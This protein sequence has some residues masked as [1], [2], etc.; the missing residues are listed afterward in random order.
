MAAWVAAWLGGWLAGSR[1]PL[2]RQS[3]PRPY[4]GTLGPGHD[5]GCPLRAGGGMSAV[6]AVAALDLER[7]LASAKL[8]RWRRQRGTTGTVYGIPSQQQPAPWPTHGV[9]SALGGE[10][11]V[12]DSRAPS[13]RLMPWA[14][15]TAPDHSDFAL[16]QL[17]TKHEAQKRHAATIQLR[18]TQ[19]TG[20]LQAL[21]KGVTEELGKFR[22]QRAMPS[23]TQ[24][25]SQLH[26]ELLECQEARQAITRTK[27][28]LAE[29]LQQAKSKRKAV[30][31]QQDHSAGS[32][33]ESSAGHLDLQTK[34]A[35]LDRHFEDVGAQLSA[36]T[37]A[38]KHAQ[39]EMQSAEQQ[40]QDLSDQLS[41]ANA[42]L[43][44]Q[45]EK[46]QGIRNYI[47]EL[48]DLL[49]KSV[50]AISTSGETNVELYK[51]SKRIDAVQ[52]GPVS[53]QD[54]DGNC[55]ANASSVGPEPTLVD[56]HF[57]TPAGQPLGLQLDEALHTTRTGKTTV[58]TVLG[59]VD[60]NSQAALQEG[61]RPGLFLLGINGESVDNMTYEHVLNQL[62]RVR[63]L[64]LTFGS[65]SLDDMSNELTE[66]EGSTHVDSIVTRADDAPK[67]EQNPPRIQLLPPQ[68]TIQ[69]AVNDQQHTGVVEARIK[70]HPREDDPWHGRTEIL[71]PPLQTL[72]PSTRTDN[73]KTVTFDKQPP[74]PLGILFTEYESRFG[75]HHY[76][77]IA[78]VQPATKSEFRELVEGLI[79]VEVNGISVTNISMPQL[80]TILKARPVALTFTEHLVDREAARAILVA[81]AAIRWKLFARRQRRRRA[82]LE[83]GGIT[84]SQ[85]Y[86]TSAAP[87]NTRRA[88][89]TSSGQLSLQSF[90]YWMRRGGSGR[91]NVVGTT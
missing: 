51:R 87:S 81:S 47:Y 53:G 66:L 73:R 67:L 26:R 48:E 82:A 32:S 29:L 45:C 7:R 34:Q 79:L 39:S 77:V 22:R 31:Y 78:S 33:E 4:L 23:S 28:D 13:G 72:S 10:H 90:D 21:I 17:L 20:H 76:L 64:S 14:G 46:N 69:P 74:E 42:A 18:H 57:D 59:Q 54:P 43:E 70:A 56:A 38:H 1:G 15:S 60:Y 30:A 80:I 52:V 12:G 5:Q 37:A 65:L 68:H 24:E 88:R 63:P 35:E 62:Q 89:R 6:D 9:Q 3:C 49:S 40:V 75:G 11:T 85:A 41:N 84:D 61:L 16:R 55:R 50:M 71:G 36:E 19:E 25:L 83:G 44:Q 91:L 2:D 86:S 27:D 58:V 8:A